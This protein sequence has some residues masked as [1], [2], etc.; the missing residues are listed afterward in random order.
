MIES[1]HDVSR[2]AES[3]YGKRVEQK[4]G[5]GL[6]LSD[7]GYWYTCTRIREPTPGS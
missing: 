5:R 2:K 7:L 6:N 3:I 1:K 4:G